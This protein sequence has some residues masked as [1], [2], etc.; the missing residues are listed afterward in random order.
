MYATVMVSWAESVDQE[1]DET[2]KWLI[3]FYLEE[4]KTEHDLKECKKQEFNGKS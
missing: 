2:S 1:V 4:R 3:F